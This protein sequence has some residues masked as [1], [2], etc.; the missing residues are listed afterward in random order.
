MI[1]TFALGKRSRAGFGTPPIA[2]N[3]RRGAT[4]AA[5]GVR[6]WG[7]R[8]GRR[9][10]TAPRRRRTE[11]TLK[12]GWVRPFRE[13]DA[14]PHVLRIPPVSCQ[15][16]DLV[17]QCQ[18]LVETP[19][20]ISRAKADPLTAA[21]QD[22]EPVRNPCCSPSHR[23]LS[24]SR[25][26]APLPRFDERSV[27]RR[28][29]RKAGNCLRCCPRRQRVPATVRMTLSTFEDRPQCPAARAWGRMSRRPALP[30]LEI[31]P[32]A[33]SSPPTDTTC[34]PFGGGYTASFPC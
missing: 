34:P 28:H 14:L 26:P 3:P 18:I 5:N 11:A 16:N 19:D 29:R 33:C 21:G 32:A 4:H 23:V 30:S 6:H 12:W 8:H 17:G 13:R 31:E 22:S 25:A 10:C 27:R 15:R 24:P 1:L 2:A 7:S 9:R 20:R